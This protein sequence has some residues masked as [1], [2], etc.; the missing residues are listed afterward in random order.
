MSNERK[1]DLSKLND[2][3]LSILMVERDTAQFKKERIDELIN[4]YGE[5]QGYLDAAKQPT[6]TPKNEATQLPGT[7]FSKLPW[8]SYK[9]K[10]TATPDEAAWIFA[11]TQGAEALLAT[12]KA[13]DGKAQVGAFEYQLQ[14]K[15]RQF[16]ARKPIK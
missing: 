7:D 6:A 14:G 3:E 10:E 5:A 2:F 12:L 1:P 13:K 4:K 11:N 15:E 16:I 8:K 9:T